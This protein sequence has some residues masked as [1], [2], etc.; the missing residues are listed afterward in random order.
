MSKTLEMF[1]EVSGIFKFLREPDV[2]PYAINEENETVTRGVSVAK[3][4]GIR[5][6]WQLALEVVAGMSWLGELKPASSLANRGMEASD[7]PKSN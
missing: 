2:S 4:D 3:I 1:R 7:E 5:T 6:R